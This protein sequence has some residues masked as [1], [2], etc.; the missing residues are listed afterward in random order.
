MD[1]F[2]S[3]NL[4]SIPL[5]RKSTYIFFPPMSLAAEHTHRFPSV[6]DR[7]FWAVCQ[8]FC[9][10]LLQALMVSKPPDQNCNCS[11]IGIF[12]GCWLIF[13]ERRVMVLTQRFWNV[14]RWM[15]FG[16]THQAAENRVWVLLY[17]LALPRFVSSRLVPSIKVLHFLD[18]RR[19]D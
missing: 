15:S 18:I 6:L 10:K 5:S 16:L 8:C 11:C 1:V 7:Q 13:V 2:E 9:P 12:V 4:L 17:H 3:F 19:I 14:S